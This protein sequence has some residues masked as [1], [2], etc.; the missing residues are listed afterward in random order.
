M[1][2]KITIFESITNTD[3]PYFVKPQEIIDRIKSEKDIDL[4]HAIRGEQD[5]DKRNSIK[6]QLPAICWSGTFTHRADIA[7]QDHS[8]LVCLDFDNYDCLEDRDLDKQTFSGNPFVYA[9]FISP[10]SNGLKVIVKIPNVAANHRS[11]FKALK[12]Y[13]DNEH[14]DDSCINESRVCYSSCDA[15]I[16]VNEESKVFTELYDDIELGN[17]V[18][19]ILFE[20][21]EE[22]II[23]ILCKWWL[24]KYG[25]NEGERNNNLHI[26]ASRFN[27][28]GLNKTSAEQVCKTHANGLKNSEIESLINSAYKRTGDF[29]TRFFAAQQPTNQIKKMTVQGVSL[30]VIAEKV[31]KDNNMNIQT[32]T[33]AVKQVQESNP[34][35]IFWTINKQKITIVASQYRDYLK[36]LG[37]YKY[38]AEKSQTFV[39]VCKKESKI[40]DITEELIKDMVLDDLDSHGHDEVWNHLAG[41]PRYF[42]EDYLSMLENC[43]ASFVEDDKDTAYLYFD[44][45]AV[46]VTRDTVEQVKY[47]DL[48]GNVWGKHC[49]DRSFKRLD[50]I[51]NDFKTLI[52][53]ISSQDDTRRQAIE[54]AI[55]FLLHS[56]KT[57]ARNRA[58]ILNDELISDNPN[59]GTGKGLF[60]SAIGHMKRVATI[61]GKNFA[62]DKSFAYQTV[63][64]DTQVLCLDDVKKNFS[65]ESLFSIITEGITL[66]KKNKDAIKLPIE[67]SPKVLISTNYALKGLGNSNER[68]KWDLEFSQHYNATRT[69]E[70]E[71]GRMLFDEWD[72]AH[73]HIFDNYMISCL[74]LYLT[75]GRI[76]CGFKNLKTKKFIGNSNQEFYDWM[77]DED[78]NNFP[79]NERQDK[80]EKY[81]KFIEDYPDYNKYLS[82]RAFNGWVE[83][84]ARHKGY[85]YHKGSSNGKRW[86]AISTTG[87]TPGVNGD[88]IAAIDMKPNF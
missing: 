57:G 41:R 85:T 12:I 56:Y 28:Y 44:N 63:Q 20:H 86:H 9:C 80:K 11:H 21:D 65:F 83:D 35:S 82:A 52:W 24:D 13:F 2:M 70:D 51:D 38:Y 26:L 84:Y 67:K 3:T 62:T 1:S 22:I 87:S 71:F 18:K 33:E 8:G 47:N 4:V 58:V 37:I 81:D 66:E 68:R 69:P 76:E 16:Y 88:E 61:D 7:L 78:V 17:F 54:S 42:K 14:F 31:A 6:R 50:T 32:A 30:E 75:H 46:K 29:S 10:S 40:F 59:G 15:D 45:T 34:V 74:Q 73:W 39:F 60:I 43:G 36:S 25:M 64:V 23:T 53:N 55:G 49:L 48:G 79:F 19:P 72:D 77:T 27:A 5:K